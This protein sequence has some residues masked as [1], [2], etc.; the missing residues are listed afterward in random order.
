MIDLNRFHIT[1]DEILR[2][3]RHFRRDDWT[4]DGEGGR[5]ATDTISYGCF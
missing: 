5:T 1:G 3:F 2:P 4:S